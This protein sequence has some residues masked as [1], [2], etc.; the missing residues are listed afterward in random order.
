MPNRNASSKRKSAEKNPVKEDAI[1]GGSKTNANQSPPP[2]AQDSPRGSV[3]D[4]SPIP[5][6]PK[7]ESGSDLS[8][9]YGTI[10]KRLGLSGSSGDQS[11]AKHRDPKEGE[12]PKGQG[13]SDES[14]SPPPLK[15]R[16]IVSPS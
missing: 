9:V 10:K 6:T 3:I 2:D 12:A 1:K 16:K 11:P 4:P 15:R 13:G 8:A 5:H 7:D 14:P